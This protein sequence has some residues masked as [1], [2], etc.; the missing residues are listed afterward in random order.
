[1]RIMVKYCGYLRKDGTYN[2]CTIDTEERTYTNNCDSCCDVFVEAYMS[3]DVDSLR[4]NV[5]RNGYKEVEKY[6]YRR[7]DYVDGESEEK[8]A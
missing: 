4:R 3:R 7:W 1:M 6:P 2:A 8:T 5:V